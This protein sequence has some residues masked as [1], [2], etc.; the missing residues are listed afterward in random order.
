MNGNIVKGLLYRLKCS[1]ALKSVLNDALITKTLLNDFNLLIKLQN[2]NNN[3]L[4]E[5][6]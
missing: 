6:N 4:K 3:R 2:E 1:T 5:D